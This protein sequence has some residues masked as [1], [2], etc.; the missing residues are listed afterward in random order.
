MDFGDAFAIVTSTGIVSTSAAYYLFKRLMDIQV[1]K[2]IDKHKADLDS[3]AAALKTDL[4]IYAH[5]R[6]VGLTRLDELRAGAIQELYGLTIKW[7]ELFLDI[8]VPNLPVSAVPEMQMQRL[9]N[10]SQNL[11]MIGDKLAIKVRDNAIYFDEES[12][13]VIA[14][15]GQAATTLGLDLRA[16]TSDK[17]A[18]NEPT[19]D[20]ATADFEAARVVLR[21]AYKEEHKQAQDALI[22]EFR[23]LMKAERVDKPH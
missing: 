8:T 23:R 20:R 19:L 5:E 7:Q 6:T 18:Q 12:Y 1:Q 3:K 9:V 2:T 16:A 21:Q 13:K 15:Y 11:A 4:E 14:A 22:K 10:W 17:W